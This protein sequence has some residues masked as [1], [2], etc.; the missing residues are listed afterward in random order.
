[1][2]TTKKSGLTIGESIDVQSRFKLR[3][4]DL[5][6]MVRICKMTSA[7][8]NER[9]NAIL[10]QMP[11]RT[12]RWVTN[13]LQGY[14]DAKL[15]QIYREDLEFCYVDTD[16]VMYSTNKK[17]EHR[18]TEEFYAKNQGHLLS[19]MPNGHYWKGSRKVWYGH[20]LT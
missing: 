9:W 16:G 10:G 3:A 19:D 4:A 2:E 12:P 7:D 1:M 11:Q 5:I 8:F 13:Y 18:L 15:E 14:R 17:S 6:S 20:A